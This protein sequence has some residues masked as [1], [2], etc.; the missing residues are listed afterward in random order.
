MGVEAWGFR[1]TGVPPP[2]FVGG[3]LRRIYIY[4]LI[5]RVVG[6]SSSVPFWYKLLSYQR[7]NCGNSWGELRGTHLSVPTQS[8]EIGPLGLS[9]HRYIQEPEVGRGITR[10]SYRKS[11]VTLP[12]PTGRGNE[13]KDCRYQQRPERHRANP[14]N[15]D[16]VLLGYRT[17]SPRLCGVSRIPQPCGRRAWSRC[18][19]S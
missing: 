6:V 16:R 4:F 18:G 14:T 12:P 9:E 5:R 15:R 19:G 11:Y 7:L 10:E 3:N 8:A 2:A 17:P 13:I 1:G